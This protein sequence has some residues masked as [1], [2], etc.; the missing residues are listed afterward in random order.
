[1]FHDQIDPEPLSSDR[2]SERLGE[3]E[4]IALRVLLRSFYFQFPQLKRIDHPRV[5]TVAQGAVDVVRDVVPILESDPMHE[6]LSLRYADILTR[7]V[8]L[9]VR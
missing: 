5:M 4:Q 2:P 9:L 8:L 7:P 6:D 1:M 3:P